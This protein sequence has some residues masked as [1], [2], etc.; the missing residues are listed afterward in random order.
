MEF[1]TTG[2]SSNLLIQV[3]LNGGDLQVDH[4]QQKV[5]WIAEL[6]NRVYLGQDGFT[7]IPVATVE[8][9]YLSAESAS[10]AVIPAGT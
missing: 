9:D 5:P 6:G 4:C 1:R 2:G 3:V 8:S 7:S 10:G